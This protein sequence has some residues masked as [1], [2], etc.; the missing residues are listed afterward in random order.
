MDLSRLAAVALA[1]AFCLP[2]SSMIAQQGGPGAGPNA[3]P[4]GGRGM[5]APTNLQV[6]PKDI[7]QQDLMRTMRGFTT[8]LGVRCNFCHANDPQTQRTNFALDTKPEKSTARLMIQ[9]TQT[10]NTQYLAKLP[11]G[12]AKITCYTCHRGSSMPDLKAPAGNPGMMGGVG[13]GGPQG[14]PPPPAQ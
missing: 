8:D 11:A 3:G 14:A 2:A 12:D 13:P 5:A 9:M 6:L 4:G 1:T 10:I 7:S